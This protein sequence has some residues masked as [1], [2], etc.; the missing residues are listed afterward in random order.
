VFR[1]VW[2]REREREKLLIS[3][4]SIEAKGGAE[5]DVEEMWATGKSVIATRA[6]GFGIKEREKE[7]SRFMP[8]VAPIRDENQRSKRRTSR[9][10]A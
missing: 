3:S 4:V 1:L 10:R 2:T 5:G 9:A 6:V 7:P 8:G